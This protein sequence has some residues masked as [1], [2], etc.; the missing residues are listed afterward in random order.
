MYVIL[1]TFESHIFYSLAAA[2]EPP[3]GLAMG[4][5]LS[6]KKA[7]ESVR[8]DLSGKKTFLPVGKAHY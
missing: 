8:E 6:V 5:L 1:S 4:A 2:G 7:V 3:I